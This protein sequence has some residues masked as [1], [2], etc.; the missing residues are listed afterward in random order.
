MIKL[1]DLF[2]T[3]FAV[4]VRWFYYCPSVLEW[5][6]RFVVVLFLHWI[7]IL[8]PCVM[9]AEVRIVTLKID[10]VTVMIGLM[11]Y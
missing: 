3:C 4:L 6:E 9:I 10:A 5:Q 1:G 2:L 8:T 7:K 11:E